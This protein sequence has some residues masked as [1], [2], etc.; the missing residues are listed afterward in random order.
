[1]SSVVSAATTTRR[2]QVWQVCLGAGVLAMIVYF[3]LGH[4]DVLPGTQVALYCSANAA[5]G[6]AAIISARRH[7]ALRAPM[8][9]IAASAISSVIGDVT[10]YFVALVSGTEVYPSIA[11][12]FYLAAYPLM[13]LG[14]LLI[15]R[16]RTPGWDG[17]SIIDASIVAIGTGF[18]VYQ[19]LIAP[20]L[21]DLTSADRFV[22][23]AYPVGDLMLIVVGSRLMLGAGPRGT[24]LR[25]IGAYL[26][27]V[28]VAD[29]V[30]SYQSVNGTF[31]AGN[32]LDA[33]W[34]TAG[35]AFAAAVLHPSAPTLVTRSNAATPD[36]TTGRLIILAVG[37]MTA[38][39][40]ILIQE[41]L[42]QTPDT[43]AA[44]IVCNLLF[45]LVLVRMTGLVRAQRLAAIT[46]GL[47]GLRS[48]R[49]FEE[50]L[51]NESARAERYQ[52][53][54]SMLLL[55]IDHFKSVNDTYGHN[56][57]DRVL[58]EVTHRLR[59]LIRPGDVVARYGGEEFAVLLPAT[60]PEQAREIAERI[61]RGVN[62]APIAVSDSRLVRVTVSVGVAGMPAVATTAELVLTADRALYAAKNAGRN[63][64]TSAADSYPTAA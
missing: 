45:L 34:M 28:L 16:R 12:V 50:A 52:L 23:V 30:Y 44:A 27:L 24:A 15:V 5:L 48:R 63:R 8:L 51:G 14:L 54:L 26:G 49:Y 64:V 62:A 46:D 3:G 39:T 4:L 59:E 22:S 31:Q 19:F 7:P 58:V 55:D 21:T 29:I 41:S 32:I 10:Y 17:A 47:T 60:G 6:V 20:Q 35:F 18:L 56:G 25:M 1:M 43:I 13:A 57:G 37:A 11:D 2:V 33:F 42:G 61:R 40:S 36:A 38:P 53:P 9:L